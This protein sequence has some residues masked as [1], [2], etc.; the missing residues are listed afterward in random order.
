[1]RPVVESLSYSL[2]ASLPLEAPA[3]LEPALTAAGIDTVGKLLDQDPE[4]I[5]SM[6]LLGH[7]AEAFSALLDAAE[8]R[9]RAVVGVTGDSVALAAGDKQLTSR[10][11]LKNAATATLFARLLG[12]RL[13]AGHINVAPAAVASAVDETSQ[14]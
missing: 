5:L 2:A 14:G 1:L 7:H 4:R 12:D 6:V 11:D 13:R 9:T 3:E 10:A 8:E